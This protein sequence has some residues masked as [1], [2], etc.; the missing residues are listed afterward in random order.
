MELFVISL[1]V[2]ILWAAAA[3]YLFPQRITFQESLIKGAITSVLGMCFLF[4]MYYK[5]MGD[6]AIVNGYVTG[7]ERV[8]VSCSHSYSCNCYTTCSGSG[9]N[10]TCTRRCSTCYEHSHDV[11]WRVYTTVGNLEIARVNRQGTKEPK[12]WTDVVINEPAASYDSYINYIKASPGSLFSMN[13]ME[14][15]KTKYGNLIPTY[16]KIFDYYRVNRVL[17]MGVNYPEAAVL[18]SALNDALRHLG[19]KKQVNIVVV[20]ANTNDPK[21]RFALERAWVGGKKNDVIVV[22]GMEKNATLLW[23]DVIT[24]GKNSGN[25]YLAVVLRDEIRDLAKRQQLSHAPLLADSIVSTITAHFKRKQMEDFKYLQEDYSPSIGSI[26]GFI[27]FQLVLLT[28]MTIFFYNYEIDG[29]YVRNHRFPTIRRRHG[30]YY[31]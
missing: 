30:S 24:F 20:F 31:N 11:D 2:I 7:K 23:T 22:I 27:I 12:R 14:S 19:A 18:N 3:H 6:T 17:Q 25:E 16:P 10:R 5:D 28:G 13:Q 8:R 9:Q 1:V 29:G 21:Y 4:A 26:W 15:D